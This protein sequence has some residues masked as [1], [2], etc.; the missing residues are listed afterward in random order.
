VR[1]GTNP[2]YR[3]CSLSTPLHGFRALRHRPFLLFPFF[4]L[5]SATLCYRK[6]GSLVR[7]EAVAAEIPTPW[8]SLTFGNAPNPMS[9]SILVH[10]KSSS[11]A[12]SSLPS[13]PPF[14]HK[15]LLTPSVGNTTDS[16]E[17]V[18]LSFSCVL[19][20]VHHPHRILSW[21]HFLIAVT[22]LSVV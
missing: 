22:L 3:L 6:V 8:I 5:L 21:R 10:G 15:R 11:L 13:F 14:P 16:E 20:D 19:N 9:D 7:T 18:R 2:F 17:T 4:Y 12:P 1:G